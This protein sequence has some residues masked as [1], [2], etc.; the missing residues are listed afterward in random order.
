MG[1]REYFFFCS[2]VSGKVR[3]LD[4]AQSHVNDTLQRTDTIVEKSNCIDG[5]QKALESDDFESAANYVKTFL[6]INGICKDSGS[7]QREM[8]SAK[9]QLETIV[10]RRLSTVVDQRDHAMVLR[11][12]SLYS[13]LAL[14]G[15]G[16]QVYFS[17]LKKVIS[18]RSKVEFEQLVELMEQNRNSVYFVTCLTNLFED[19]VMTI[20]SCM[21]NLFKDIVV[22]DNRST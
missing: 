13:P 2:N 4:L 7:D 10:R 11:F 20:N 14:N 18:I 17:Y 3:E 8:F 12:I 5:V 16:S 1:R 9:K 21:T 19:I 22:E 6:E 15:E